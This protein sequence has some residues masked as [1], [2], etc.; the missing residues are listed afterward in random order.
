MSKETDECTF[1]LVMRLR[2]DSLWEFILQR[3]FRG[4]IMIIWNPRFGT[5]CLT[6]EDGWSTEMPVV[7]RMEACKEGGALSKKRRRNRVC[8]AVPR[9]SSPTPAQLPL[10]TAVDLSILRGK[11]ATKEDI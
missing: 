11:A 4:L 6:F 1:M 9:W 5:K 3:M 8:S 7:S 2:I 10:H